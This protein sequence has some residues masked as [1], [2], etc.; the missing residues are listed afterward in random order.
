MLDSLAVNAAQASKGAMTD[1]PPGRSILYL[2]YD[3]MTDPLGQSQV[4]PYLAGLSK[5]GHRISLISFEKSGRSQ[6]ERETVRALCGKA[7][8]DWHPQVYHK[9]PPLLS[10]V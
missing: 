6:A 8:I 1:Q 2:S 5:R 3:G 4:L 7:G 10:S 9:R